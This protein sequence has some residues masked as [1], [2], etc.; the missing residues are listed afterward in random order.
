MGDALGIGLATS[1]ASAATNSL[2]P[3]LSLRQQRLIGDVLL[4]DHYSMLYADAHGTNVNC[5]GSLVDLLLV[6]LV[7]SREA[8]ITI[9]CVTKIASSIFRNVQPSFDA[10]KAIQRWIRICFACQ[11]RDG[12]FL[13]IDPTSG[14]AVPVI[15]C[16]Y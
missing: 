7:R 9:E 4:L 5:N 1:F 15:Q 13:Y 14:Q 16:V 10:Q 11:H 3:I 8:R 6:I 12:E 2:T